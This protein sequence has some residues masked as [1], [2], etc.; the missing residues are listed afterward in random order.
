[1][2]NLGLILAGVLAAG[3]AGA[4]TL[5]RGPAA[6]AAARASVTLPQ[7]SIAQMGDNAPVAAGSVACSDPA[8]AITSEQ[9]W[10]RRFYLAE[11]GA[12]SSVQIESVMVGAEAG[13]APV[14]IRLYSI[15]HATPVDTLPRNL[16]RPIG[17]SQTVMVYGRMDT[18]TIPVAGLLADAAGDDL[19]VE[20][21]TDG[22]L[23]SAFYAGANASAETHPSFLSAPD[24]GLP[25][26]ARVGDIGFA[27][28][29]MILVAQAA[30]PGLG[31][32]ASFA[33][34]TIAAGDSARLQIALANSLPA[35]AGLVAPFAIT[36]PAGLVVAPSPNADSTCGGTLAALAGG[37]SLSLTGA[38]IAAQG[39]CTLSVDVTA[40]G[41]VF[42]VAIAADALRTDR[43][44]NAHATRARITVVPA[45]GNGLI[46]SGALNRALAMTGVGTSYDLVGNVFSDTG[47]LGGPWDVSFGLAQ[48]ANAAA[49]VTLGFNTAPAVEFALDGNGHVAMLGDGDVVGPASTFGGGQAL[50]PDPR[51]YAGADRAVG[52][53]FRCAGRLTYPVRGGE[54]C[55]GY[56]RLTTTL[57]AGVPARLIESVFQGDGDALTVQ[58]P[59]QSDPPTASV[60]PASIWLSV[61]ANA[62][63]HQ[64]LSLANAPGSAPLRYATA[65]RGMTMAAQPTTQDLARP[66]AHAPPP[67]SP[68]PF[69]AAAGLRR[70]D[71]RGFDPAPWSAGGGFP[72]VLDDGTY[73]FILGMGVQASVWLNRYS[74]IEAQTIDSISVMWPTQT[75]GGSLLGLTANLVAYYDAD[76]DGDPRNAVRLGS[77]EIV[78]I[79]A[80][81]RFRTYPTQFEVPGPGDVYIGIV[82]HWAMNGY[83]Y[84][85]SAAAVDGTTYRAASYLSINFPEPGVPP[86]LDIDDLGANQA[87][88]LLGAMGI[89]G[90]FVF[91]ATGSG[92]SC[93]GPAVPW[94]RAEG[95]A[96]VVVGGAAAMLRFQIDPAAG[97]LEP[98]VHAAELCIV[99]NDPAHRVLSV[100]ITVQVTPPLAAH[101][102]STTGDNLFCDGFDRD[103]RDA[104]VHSGLLDVDLPATY[105]G[106]SFNFARGDWSEAPLYGDDFAP[107]R[108]VLSPFMLFY[109]HGDGTSGRGGGVADTVFGPYRVL[110]SGDTIGPDSVFSEVASGRYDETRRFLEG[111]DGYLGFRFYDEEAHQ[112]RYGYIH[113]QTTWPSG[114]PAKV[115]G[116]GYDRSG[117]PITIP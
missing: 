104:I 4:A 34:A 102:C 13:S 49:V 95:D 39:H 88:V 54:Y 18:A 6:A 97:G 68:L 106:M 100:P 96:G 47:R 85:L 63:S 52:I 5:Q 42:D 69:A 31:V 22:S 82:E 19:V 58:L 37:G 105:Y 81:D 15:P 64:Q 71:V 9:S 43:G 107:F 66:D 57:P 12:P 14:T 44:S 103:A 46:R 16:L 111:V 117:G 32:L 29:H 98:G 109:W 36:L 77:D 45:G 67:A 89:P 86:H 72:Y 48:D 35:P 24:C 10:W 27:D 113:L 30:A 8:N 80:I 76:A 114:Y 101:A 116:Y 1:M 74:V 65:G 53:R 83:P 73:E 3:A 56:V 21:H 38:A 60:S 55:F 62:V 23:D 79:D 75:E 99:S 33:P 7:S 17:T 112:T 92:A 40:D 11:H 59:P 78:T 41:G 51:W 2:K 25:E 115:L 26:P 108:P 90:N 28:A 50:S 93:S 84:P 94:L 91:R 20:Y 87:T 70:T 61:E 110:H